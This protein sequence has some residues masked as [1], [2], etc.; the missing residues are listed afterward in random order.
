MLQDA[1]KVT[2]EDKT[3]ECGCQMMMVTYK[4]DKT[5]FA[6][7]SAEKSGCVFCTPEF[8]PLV[9]FIKKIYC[10][11]IYLTNSCYTD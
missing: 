11:S 7:G 3:C 10:K 2:V 9:R 6:D 8:A 4:A 5:P 1:I